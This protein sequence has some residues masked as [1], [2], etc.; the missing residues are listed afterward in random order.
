MNFSPAAAV[1]SWRPA[2]WLRGTGEDA[3]NF[4]QG[5]FTNEL[6]NVPPGAAVY[7][8]WLTLKGK[9]LADS[10]VLRDSTPP[11][12]AGEG[13]AGAVY[14]IGTY[15]APAATIRERLETFI[16]ADDVVVE[17][18]TADWA[19][20][21]V[22][23][24]G[25]LAA[26]TAAASETGIGLVF[27]GRRGGGEAAEWLF[28]L[29]QR[30]AALVRVAGLR[31]CDPVELERRRL[32]AGLPAV[33][34]D[35]GPADLPGEGGLEDDAISYTKGCYLGQEV[36]ARLK[37]MGQVRR[38]LHRVAGPG[39]APLV[40]PVDLLAGDRKVGD[41]RSV[42]DDGS[43]GWIGLAMLSLLHTAPGA[44]LTFAGSDPA[45]TVRV[46]EAV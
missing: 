16:V 34:A 22:L 24:A 26:T 13:R 38:R 31:T 3:G 40:R 30:D 35:I 44:E 45:S 42:V 41:L 33:P 32:A 37:S 8:L 9:V 2:A 25:A 18:L 5:Q 10:F 7:G 20:L 11:A 21:T 4:L 43:G 36:M 29:A 28:P 12:P 27:P 14:W 1:F 39:A 15:T 19:A 23:G 46:G 6:R 17:D